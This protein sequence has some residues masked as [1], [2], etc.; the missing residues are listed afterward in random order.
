MAKKAKREF[1]I[2]PKFSLEILAEKKNTRRYFSF[3]KIRLS[4]LDIFF[5]EAEMK[6]LTVPALNILLAVGVFLILAGLFLISY[7]SSD[8]IDKIPV[9]SLSVMFF[10][11]LIFYITLV[12]LKW[13]ST[14]FAGLYIFACG[15]L[16]TFIDFNVVES[17][18]GLLWPLFSVF[19]GICLILTCIFK[20]RKIRGVYLFPSVILVSLGVLFL[21]FTFD[22]I[23]FSFVSFFSKW[24]PAILIFLGAMLVGIFIYQQNS[25]GFFPYD[26]DELSDST[27]DSDILSGD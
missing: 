22:V 12:W 3:Q 2:L 19:G 23:H 14:F 4:Y 17:G 24:F 8:F 21:L 27:D 6:K 26:K 10:G 9:F 18:L 11:A 15:L 20:H 1:P 13:A 5:V 25:K 16:F 7:F